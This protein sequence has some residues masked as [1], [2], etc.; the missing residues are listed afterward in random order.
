MK[1]NLSQGDTMQKHADA[2]GPVRAAKLCD[3]KAV[4]GIYAPAVN[5][6]AI[7]FE[8]EAPDAAE[9]GG[10]IEKTLKRWPWLVYESENRVLGYAYACA[11]RER[12][13]YQWDVEVS[14]YVH[15]QAQ[16]RGIGRALYT[17]LFAI[18]KKQ[19]Y[20]NAYAGIALPNLPSVALHESLGFRPVGVYRAVGYKL[21]AWHDVAWGHLALQDPLPDPRSPVDFCELEKMK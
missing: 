9:M 8:F 2:A 17:E 10:R 7:S 3:A 18:L 5:G 19:G 13:A 6:S 4:A 1:K 12:A 14:V 21:N 15:P 16:R 11:H 20:I